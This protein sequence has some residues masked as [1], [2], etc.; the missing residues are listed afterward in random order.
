MAAEVP[1]GA[2]VAGF[3]QKASKNRILPD[4]AEEWAM[5]SLKQHAAQ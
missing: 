5:A 4:L 2:R 1:G 3:T